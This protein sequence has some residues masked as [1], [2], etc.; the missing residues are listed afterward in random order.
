MY[1]KI[2]VKTPFAPFWWVAC[3]LAAY[4]RAGLTDRQPQQNT[5]TVNGMVLNDQWG[6]K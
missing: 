1:F 4:R 3:L 5:M 6:T 2:Q